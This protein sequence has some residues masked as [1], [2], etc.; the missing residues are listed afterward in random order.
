MKKLLL[1][2]LFS[3]MIVLPSFADSQKPVKY[4]LGNYNFSFDVKEEAQS[5]EP[6]QPSS[7]IAP[8]QQDKAT[9][10]PALMPAK[11]VVIDGNIKP[12]AESIN[13]QKQVVKQIKEEEQAKEDAEETQEQTPQQEQKLIQEPVKQNVCEPSET[14]KIEAPVPCE[15]NKEE[16]TTPVPQSSVMP[17]KEN[18]QLKTNLQPKTH[19]PM[20]TQKVLDEEHSAGLT[21]GETPVKRVIQPTKPP[22]KEQPRP[23][24]VEEEKMDE[25]TLTKDVKTETDS[26]AQSVENSDTSKVN[27]QKNET[28][29]EE[30]KVKEKKKLP[31]SFELHQMQYNGVE[32]RQL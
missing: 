27:A 9:I 10:L 22:A 28:K 23:K 7:Q 24:V 12:I 1:T 29:K 20:P 5:V 15:D 6:T 25:I 13:A 3:A 2:A 14:P 11:P 8:Q 4:E 17:S 19:T 30:Q 18:L 32:S 26:S 31:F 16:V 21:N